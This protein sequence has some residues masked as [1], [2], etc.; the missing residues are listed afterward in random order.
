MSSLTGG[1]GASPRQMPKAPSGY[2][3]YQQYT[4]EQMDLLQQ[5]HGHAAPDSFLNQIASGDQSRFAETEAPALRQFNELQGNIASRFSGMGTGGRKSSGFQNAS[6]A[7]GSN[8]AQDLQAR[9]YEMQRQAIQDL[10]GLSNDLLSKQPYGLV[11]KREKQGSGWGGIAGGALGAI[12]GTL[13]GN[14]M[15]GAS[16]GYGIGSSFDRGGGGG[17]NNLSGLGEFGEFRNPF[18]SSGSQFSG[19][20]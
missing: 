15:L 20:Y 5:M 6:T 7:A 13:F 18:A 17:M 14:P 9:R 12:G 11:Q 3:R 4:P 1:T 8:F 10:R 2:R 16:L 19:G